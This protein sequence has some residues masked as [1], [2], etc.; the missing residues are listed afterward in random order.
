MNGVKTICARQSVSVM[1]TKPGC[2]AN[3][4]SIPQGNLLV[5]NEPKWL[6]LEKLGFEARMYCFCINRLIEQLTKACRS[7]FAKK[8]DI[9]KS[10]A[11]LRLQFK[12][13]LTWDGGLWV[14]GTKGGK[15]YGVVLC[16]NGYSEVFG[17]ELHQ[18]AFCLCGFWFGKCSTDMTGFAHSPRE[19]LKLI[20]KA[21]KFQSPFFTRP[22]KVL[23]NES[24]LRSAFES[25]WSL[26]ASVQGLENQSV[27][28]TVLENWGW[29]TVIKCSDG[30][31]ASLS[32]C[33]FWRKVW[34]KTVTFFWPICTVHVAVLLF[35]V[36]CEPYEKSV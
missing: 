7:V 6:L 34:L 28:G 17:V 9:F 1:W 24:E 20:W 3:V 35:L 22:L 12:S 31:N 8:I 2:V 19:C 26:K 15:V 11:N 27:P 30:T 25:P 18:A 29:C 4:S 32:H 23:K 16:V 13:P 36:L 33:C 10:Q 14:A 5:K 21:L